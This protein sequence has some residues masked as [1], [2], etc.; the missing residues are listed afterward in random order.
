MW[1]KEEAQKEG[2]AKATKL[3]N[4]PMSH[5]L[6]G[7]LMQNQSSVMVEVHIY[8]RISFYSKKV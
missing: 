3:Q 7:V 8:Y 1:L 2:W 4:R 6:V 5:G